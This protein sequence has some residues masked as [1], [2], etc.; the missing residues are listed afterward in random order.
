MP[1]DTLWLSL[2]A[3]VGFVA[4]AFVPM[5]R[6]GHLDEI[7]DAVVWLESDDARYVPGHTLSVD[8]GACAV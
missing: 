5:G 8:G 3:V 6:I 7:A 2:L 4:G 1:A